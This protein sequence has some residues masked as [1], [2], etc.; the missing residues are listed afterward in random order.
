MESWEVGRGGGCRLEGA[1][2]EQELVAGGPR[3]PGEGEARAPPPP[4]Q[5][6]GPRKQRWKQR[7]AFETAAGNQVLRLHGRAEI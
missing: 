6:P 4:P 3:K 2:P 7:R 1:V 5:E